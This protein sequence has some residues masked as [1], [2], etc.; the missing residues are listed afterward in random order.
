MRRWAIGG[1]MGETDWQEGGRTY[2]GIHELVPSLPQ[3]RHLWVNERVLAVPASD[4]RDDVWDAKPFDGEF[5]DAIMSRTVASPQWGLLACA[6]AKL[7]SLRVGFGP[8]NASWVTKVLSLCDRTRLKAFGFDW[9][10]QPGSNKPGVFSEL[11]IALSKFESLVDLHILHPYAALPTPIDYSRSPDLR[12]AV[13]RLHE[14]EETEALVKEFL[15]ALPG[16]YRVGM[17]RNSVWERQTRW[18]ENDTDEFFVQR[19]HKARVP[20]FYDAGSSL[21]LTSQGECDKQPAIRDVLKL[22]EEL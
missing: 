15:L 8:L 4:N 16:L 6:F 5:H 18:K 17:G 10:W 7:E 22:L 3:L 20:F 12:L 21:P 13:R 1:R 14:S 19:L 2:V 11:I 9:E